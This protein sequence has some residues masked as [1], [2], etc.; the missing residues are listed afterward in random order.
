MMFPS[1]DRK[2]YNLFKKAAAMATAGNDHVVDDDELLTC[3]S[4]G[5]L[6][7]SER[8]GVERHLADCAHCRTTLDELLQRGVLTLPDESAVRDA[9]VAAVPAREGVKSTDAAGTVREWWTR[10]FAFGGLALAAGMLLLIAV[11]KSPKND[12][13]QELALVEQKLQAGEDS[14]AMDAAEKL[15]KRDLDAAMKQ[16]TLDVLLR[17]GRSAAGRRLAGGNFAEV[18]QLTSRL[19]QHGLSAAEV[20]N[21][22][23][24]ARLKIADERSL[25]RRN[26][27]V[28]FGYDLDGGM[29][30]APLEMPA[31]Q[32]KSLQEEFAAAVA[33]NPQDTTLIANYGHFLMQVGKFAA[34]REQFSRAVALAPEDPYGNLGRGLAAYAEDDFPAAVKDFEAAAAKLEENASVHLNLALT[35]ERLGKRSEAVTQWTRAAELTTDP[36]RRQAIEAHLKALRG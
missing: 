1:R 28:D 6:T 21:L 9:I 5:R 29:S 32:I 19:K 17:S 4:L 30:R 34:A 12:A 26:S 3:W 10:T 2:L 36:Q 18:E 16:K 8:A 25:R 23:L 14:A 11:W 7:T 24:Q 13:E 33:A 35:Y 31:E 22:E 27:L 15:L 20:K